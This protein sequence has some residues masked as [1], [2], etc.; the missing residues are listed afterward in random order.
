MMKTVILAS[1]MLAL[2]LS[3]PVP[4]AHSQARPQ[5]WFMKCSPRMEGLVTYTVVFEHAPTFTGVQQCNGQVSS[6]G[7][8]EVWPVFTKDMGKVMGIT[9]DVELLAHYGPTELQTTKRLPLVRVTGGQVAHRFK[10]HAFYVE[11][12]KIVDESVQVR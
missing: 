7:P 10:A 3:G 8:M 6:G 5:S 4:L 12:N 2:A 9:L 11:G 1:L